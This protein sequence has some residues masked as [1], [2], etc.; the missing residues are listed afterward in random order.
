MLISTYQNNFVK[1]R[2]IIVFFVEYTNCESN[3]MFVNIILELLL[4]AVRDG[5]VV[6]SENDASLF[7]D[8]DFRLLY[9]ERPVDP[10]EPVGRK[11]FLHRLQAGE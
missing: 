7:D 5:D 1:K 4:V 6:F 9:D 3:N 2:R 11:F 8:L 10:D